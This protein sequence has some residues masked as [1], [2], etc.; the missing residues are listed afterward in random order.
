MSSLKQSKIAKSYTILLMLEREKGGIVTY[1]VSRG[2]SQ[3]VG[4]V[5]CS[6][7]SLFLTLLQ[8]TYTS[9]KQYHVK[10]NSGA[11]LYDIFSAG[12]MGSRH[13]IVPE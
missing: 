4:N 9:W 5:F 12:I 7:M 2:T 3:H 11:I 6:M 8:S 10:R 1:Y 13:S